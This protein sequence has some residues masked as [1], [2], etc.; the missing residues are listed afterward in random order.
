M[1]EFRCLIAVKEFRIVSRHPQFHDC[2]F[3]HR[4][5]GLKNLDGSARQ[6]NGDPA[7]HTSSPISAHLPSRNE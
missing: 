4:T 7:S 5:K 2:S 3:G 1:C 6:G